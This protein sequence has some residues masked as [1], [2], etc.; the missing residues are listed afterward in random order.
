MLL[1]RAV[2][3]EAGKEDFLVLIIIVLYAQS[4]ELRNKA[5]EKD[6]T[7]KLLLSNSNIVQE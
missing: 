4:V 7:L 5:M 6:V 2:G 1:Y 3:L